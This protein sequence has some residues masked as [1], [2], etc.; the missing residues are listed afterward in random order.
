MR[1]YLVLVACMLGFAT[2][3]NCLPSVGT[4]FGDLIQQVKGALGR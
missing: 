4:T 3:I 2:Q 1:K